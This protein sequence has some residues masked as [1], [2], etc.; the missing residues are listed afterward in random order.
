MNENITL[1]ELDQ[2][3]F[4]IQTLIGRLNNDYAK[5]IKQDGAAFTEAPV[6]KLSEWYPKGVGY[7]KEGGFGRF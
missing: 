7:Q 3:E 6:Y 5:Y 2:L 1:H 4:K